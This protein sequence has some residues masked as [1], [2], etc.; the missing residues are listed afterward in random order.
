MQ[1]L[2][3]RL[4]GMTSSLAQ[5]HGLKTEK[6][7]SS[8]LINTKLDNIPEHA[9]DSSLDDFSF[10]NMSSRFNTPQKALNYVNSAIS[11]INGSESHGEIDTV[12]NQKVEFAALSKGISTPLS[13]DCKKEAVKLVLDKTAHTAK[14]NLENDPLVN[15]SICAALCLSQNLFKSVEHASIAG[16]DFVV[17]KNLSGS[18]KKLGLNIFKPSQSAQV[19]ND[20]SK[21]DKLVKLVVQL[22]KNSNPLQPHDVSNDTYAKL[23]EF[24][25]FMKTYSEYTDNRKNIQLNPNGTDTDYNADNILKAIGVLDLSDVSFDVSET[26]LKNIQAVRRELWQ[27][28][29]LNNSSEHGNL[30]VIKK[31]VTHDELEVENRWCNTA[32]LKQQVEQAEKLRTRPL[33][34][35]IV[36]QTSYETLQDQQTNFWN[37]AYIDVDPGCRRRSYSVHTFDAINDLIYST[38]FHEQ[39]DINVNPWTNTFTYNKVPYPSNGGQG[40]QTVEDYQNPLTSYRARQHNKTAILEIQVPV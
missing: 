10:K 33:H 23:K 13:F 27:T 38:H 35:T 12:A 3:H 11:T 19:L 4:S 17:T 31:N 7:E 24:A 29:P 26:I 25:E 18:D 22:Y 39:V 20:I 1:H 40:P 9:N 16:S 15:K 8:S 2:S 32:L 37:Q 21:N 6:K 5:I 36:Q 14:Q 30:I 28:N 34:G